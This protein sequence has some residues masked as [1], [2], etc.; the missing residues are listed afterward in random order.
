MT[1]R[2]KQVDVKSRGGQAA[3]EQRENP[4]PSE[5]FDWDKAIRLNRKT[6]REVYGS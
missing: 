3:K 1:E 5:T 2:Q 4:R 6:R